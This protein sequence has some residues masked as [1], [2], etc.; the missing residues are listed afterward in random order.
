LLEVGA[1]MVV[2]GLCPEKLRAVVDL[3]EAAAES[4]PADLTVFW[5]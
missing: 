2:A 4:C 5:G 1:K 3:V